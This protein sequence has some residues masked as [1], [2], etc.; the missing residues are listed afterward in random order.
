MFPCGVR[1][2]KLKYIAAIATKTSSPC[3]QG[4]KVDRHCVTI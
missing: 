1:G 3:T 4:W 2:E